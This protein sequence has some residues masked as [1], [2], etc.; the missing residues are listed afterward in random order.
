[1]SD[2]TILQIIP[3]DE[4]CPDSF[5]NLSQILF[6]FFDQKMN[7]IGHQAICVHRIA[8]NVLVLLQQGKEPLIILFILKYLLLIDSTEYDMIDPCAALFPLC[9]RHFPH[10]TLS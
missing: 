4:A 7:M 3:V 8:A 1:M 6:P 9:S 10:P 5:E 2:P